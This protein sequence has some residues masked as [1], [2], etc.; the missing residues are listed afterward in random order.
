MVKVF[1]DASY[2]DKRGVC[3]IGI[4]IQ[5][6]VKQRTISNW[7]YATNVHYGE[8]FA[9]Y[10][11]AVLCNGK[12]ATIYTDSAVAIAYL[13]NEVKERP[14]TTQ[15]YYKHQEMRVLAYKINKLDAKVDK[16]KAHC[17]NF[18]QAAL[19]NSLADILSKMG[20]SKYYDFL[21]D[22]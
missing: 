8:M 1:T 21:L 16:V 5:D 14:R 22:K 12:D 3:G 19:S 17:N 15:Q 6:G 4:V 2:D 20:R 9:I 7:V 13:N 18:K 10:M 11:A